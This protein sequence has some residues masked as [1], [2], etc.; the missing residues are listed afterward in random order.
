MFRLSVIAFAYVASLFYV[1]GGDEPQDVVVPVPFEEALPQ[2]RGPVHVPVDY[3]ASSEY[4]DMESLWPALIPHL[5]A[6]YGPCGEFRPIAMQV[7]WQAAEWPKLGRIIARETGRTCDPTVLNDNADTGDLS[8]GLTQINMRGRLGP[9]R[10]AR[11]ELNV[12]EDLW[13]AATNLR[14]AR[15]LFERS[16]W[17]PWRMPGS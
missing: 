1:A 6:L 4:G 9:D 7:G 5:R 2:Y 3:N 12:Y 14:C 15:V 8:Y 17:E 13:D 11:C 10:V 16:G